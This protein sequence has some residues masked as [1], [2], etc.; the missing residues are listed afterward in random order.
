LLSIIFGGTNEIHIN[1]KQV[2]QISLGHAWRNHFIPF[3]AS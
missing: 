3:L 2:N 1:T